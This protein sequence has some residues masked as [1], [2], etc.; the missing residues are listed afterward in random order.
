MSFS[1]LVEKM[2]EPKGYKPEGGPKK[3]NP[4][5]NVRMKNKSASVKE[6]YEAQNDAKTSDPGEYVGRGSKSHKPMKLF[7]GYGSKEAQDR[8]RKNLEDAKKK[9]DGVKESDDTGMQG[10]LD[11]AKKPEQIKKIQNHI[12]HVKDLLRK[13]PADD[14]T[15]LSAILAGLKADLKKAQ[16]SESVEDADVKHSTTKDT[17]IDH[18]KVGD[19]VVH[20]GK[21]RTVGKDHIKHDSFMGKTLW[22]DSYKL[23]KTPVK[24]VVKYR[25]SSAKI[26]ESVEDAD[27]H[28]QRAHDS[29]VSAIAK[30]KRQ[31]KDC[32][33]LEKIKAS[34]A[35]HLEEITK[36]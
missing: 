14:K 9:R 18:I 34:L 4:W 24:K 10:F 11:K 28:I 15:K 7:G 22:G 1:T 16:V 32:S 33:K 12:D 19:L 5:Q 17:H 31:G 29:L 8:A 20:D 21:V 36:E 13:A 35:S 30:N 25:Q 2:F 27:H 6:D 23:G 3:K 26:G